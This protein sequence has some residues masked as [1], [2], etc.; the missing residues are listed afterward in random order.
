MDDH[1]EVTLNQFSRQA[2]PFE[3]LP[4][5]SDSIDLLVELACPHRDDSFLDIACGPGLVACHF[6]PLVKEVIG[7]DLTPAML[8]QAS[9]RQKKQGI[10]NAQWVEGNATSLPFHDS[11]FSIVLTRYSLHHFRDPAAVL[12]EMSRV[13]ETG[14]RVIV[15]DVCLPEDKAKYYD[16]FELLRDPSHVHALSH[17]E[18]KTLVT[19]AGLSEVRFAGYNVKVGLEEQLSASFPVEGGAERI[20]QLLHQDIGTNRLGV[21]AHIEN[22]E[23]QYEIPIVVAVGTKA[24]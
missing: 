12:R 4:A 6:A 19:Q 1:Q 18:L 7:V 24:S 2:I 14:G 22:R 17:S 15:A 10:R 11:A 8:V 16:E 21:N 23:I 20:R 5:H 9:K 13:C 3:Q